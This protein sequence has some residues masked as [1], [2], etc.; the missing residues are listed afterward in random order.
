MIKPELRDTDKKDHF[1]LYIDGLPVTKELEKSE[2]RY[3]MQT[4]D[5]KID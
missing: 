5:N 3:L 4:I 2:Y 1:V